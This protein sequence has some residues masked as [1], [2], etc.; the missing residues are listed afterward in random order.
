[1]RRHRLSVR[2]PVRRDRVQAAAGRAVELD[3]AVLAVL[4]GLV[5]GRADAGGARAAAQ[6]VDL[7]EEADVSDVVLETHKLVKRFGG[8]TAT[9]DVSLVVRRGA[10]HALIG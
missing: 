7:V 10:R 2:R 4:A 5:P 9:N 3:A 6:A 1:H 8:L